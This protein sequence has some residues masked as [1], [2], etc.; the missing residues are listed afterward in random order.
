MVRLALQNERGKTEVF[1]A[2]T[3]PFL[4]ARLAPAAEGVDTKEQVTSGDPGFTDVLDALTNEGSLTPPVSEVTRPGDLTPP[5]I[6]PVPLIQPESD[7]S[8]K[9]AAPSGP[10]PPLPADEIVAALTVRPD[11]PRARPRRS[12]RR[13]S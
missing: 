11:P 13:V 3:D 12:N 6:L 8:A 2:L 9:V 10:L 4:A 1:V 7:P 5:H